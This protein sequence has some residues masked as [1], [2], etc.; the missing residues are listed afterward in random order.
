MTADQPTPDTPRIPDERADTEAKQMVE[1][2][3]DSLV[4]HELYRMGPDE[5]I[6]GEAYK[7]A[8]TNFLSVGVHGLVIKEHQE[9]SVR[10]IDEMR[11]ISASVDTR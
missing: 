4:D 2:H 1:H 10:V 6:T 9:G 3:R 7:A 5:F 8:L 11:I